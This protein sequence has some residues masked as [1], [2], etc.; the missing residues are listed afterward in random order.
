MKHLTT[1]AAAALLAA[2]ISALAAGSLIPARAQTQCSTSNGL[3]ICQ[4]RTAG[5]YSVRNVNDPNV[6]ID[7][8]CGG[9]GGAVWGD[10]PFPTA[11]ELHSLFCPGRSLSPVRN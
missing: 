2:P 9:G 4:N 3:Q 5:T 8:K 10:M 11:E 1:I 7:G 6:Y